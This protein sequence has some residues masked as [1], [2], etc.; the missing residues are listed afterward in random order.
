[1]FINE[2]NIVLKAGIEM[3]LQSKFT[4]HRIVMTVY[5]CID[6]VHSLEYL[7]DH[8]WEGFGKRDA[9]SSLVRAPHS[10]AIRTDT[11]WEHSFVVNV[12][13]D[14]AHQMLDVRWS[15]HLRRSFVIFG[16]LPQV[17]E[18]INHI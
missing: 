3:S 12:A 15:R 11:T 18:P 9:C 6:P 5:V 7:T 17:L 4:N 10:N 16:I 1:M 8:A 13:L 2:E 14:P